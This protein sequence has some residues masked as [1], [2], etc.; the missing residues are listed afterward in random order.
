[1]AKAGLRSDW[2]RIDA[3]S[4]SGDVKGLIGELA[5]PKDNDPDAEPNRYPITVRG[6]AARELGRLRDPQAVVPLVTLLGEDPLP[7]VRADAAIAL[8]R[9]GDKEASSA[10]ISALQDENR[11]VRGCAA[12]SLG[13]LED[14]HAV[15]A[16]SILLQDENPWIRLQAAKALARIGDSRGVKPLASA[17]RA[18]SFRHPTFKLGLLRRLLILCIRSRGRRTVGD[19]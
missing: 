3:M 4:R 11:D 18:E 10:L 5:N 8:G 15:D 14:N 9:I 19:V 7:T 17:V 6:L 12:R 2:T 1:M 13:Q 16:L